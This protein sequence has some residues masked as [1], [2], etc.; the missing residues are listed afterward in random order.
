MKDIII[1][2]GAPGSGKTTVAELLQKETKSPLIDFSDLRVWHLNPDWS[3][4]NLEEEDMAYENFLFVIQSYV[5]HG[6]KNIIVTDL[7]DERVVD[8]ANKLS[9]LDLLVVSLVL[10]DEK[11]LEKRIQNERRSGFK[12]VDD[13]LSRNKKIIERPILPNELR[14]DNSHNEPAKTVVEILKAS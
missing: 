5:K 13:A 6:Y 3:N 4:A 10:S 12:N 11:K 7:K 9:K 8:L 14:V 1:F 2:S